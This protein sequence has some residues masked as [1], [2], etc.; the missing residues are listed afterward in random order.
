MRF[1][2]LFIFCA[3]AAP[4]ACGGNP[5]EPAA[6]CE[7]ECKDGTAL[8]ALRET[9]RV[10]YN[11][12]LMGMP[13]GHQDG[14]Y[15]CLDGG[16]AHVFGEASSNPSQGSTCVDLTYVFVDCLHYSVPSPTPER[17]Y[18]MTLVGTA[19]QKG[20][21]AVQPTAT[22][23]LRITSMAMSFH[24]QVNDPPLPYEEVDCPVDV[25]QDGNTV[26]GLLCARAAGF[27]F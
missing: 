19:T 20:I 22:T 2:P 17:N 27:G 9:M 7:Q 21:I 8:R 4:L 12:E 14:T 24:G 15:D 26:S 13:V 18:Q 16:T 5:P 11:G 25:A 6:P 23:S 3:I 10:A 1:S